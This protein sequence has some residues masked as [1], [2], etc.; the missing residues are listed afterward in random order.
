VH[1]LVAN[2]ANI[3]QYTDS[4]FVIAKMMAHYMMKIMKTQ[5]QPNERAEFIRYMLKNNLTATFEF[6]QVEHQHIEVF[7][8][9]ASKFRF[10]AFTS[11]EQ[12][13]ELCFDIV[14]GAQIARQAG[15]ETTTI[16]E[17]SFAEQD[18]LFNDIR[19]HTYGKE[20]SVLYYANREGRVIGMMKKKTIW[21]IIVRAIREKAKGLIGSVT[22][23][24]KKG[25][26][27]DGEATLKKFANSLAQTMAQ[28]R[29]WLKLSESTTNEWLNLANQFLGWLLPRIQAGEIEGVKFTNEYPLIWNRFLKETDLSDKIA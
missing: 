8:F 21:Y 25:L 13:A 7:D 3:D 15:W 9:S 20:G 14:K 28:K 5:L 23:K 2:E 26:E 1:L 16:S 12:A 6:L 4:R 11:H 10:I 29:D 22:G 18:N 27:V 17:H 24:M 19:V